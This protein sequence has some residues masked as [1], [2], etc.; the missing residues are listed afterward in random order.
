MVVNVS[1]FKEFVEK[2]NRDINEKYNNFSVQLYNA[3]KERRN[4]K[5]GKKKQQLFSL[6]VSNLGKNFDFNYGGQKEVPGQKGC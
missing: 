6:E 5:S 1:N 3:R 2:I 4:N